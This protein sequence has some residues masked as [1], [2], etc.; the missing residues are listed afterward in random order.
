MRVHC[1]IFCFV[2]LPQTRVQVSR[3]FPPSRLTIMSQKTKCLVAALL[4]F[5]ILVAGAQA[6]ATSGA[7]N[8]L[9]N[10][11]LMLGATN[12]T[13]LMCSL[14]WN[15]EHGT[16]Y[17]NCQH[18]AGGCAGP[19]TFKPH[20]TVRES[21]DTDLLLSTLRHVCFL[22]YATVKGAACLRLAPHP[23][24]MTSNKHIKQH[25]CKECSSA[26]LT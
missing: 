7:D 10:R 20:S 19:S 18:S 11:V 14:G 13:H 5:A 23:S 24:Y 4:L 16:N 8:C 3:T 2:Y 22:L 17:I 9:L 1:L 15:V 25:S 12:L 21:R 26:V 6:S